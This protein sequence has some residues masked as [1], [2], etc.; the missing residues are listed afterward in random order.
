MYV[1]QG[2]LAKVSIKKERKEGIQ[3][4][5]DSLLDSFFFLRLKA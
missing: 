2:T 4:N 5:L 1:T 3:L